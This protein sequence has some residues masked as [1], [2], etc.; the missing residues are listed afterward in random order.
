MKIH[1][2]KILIDFAGSVAVGNKLFEIRKNDRGYQKGDFVKFKAIN[3]YGIE[4]R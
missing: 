1:D 4:I 3:K 2:L